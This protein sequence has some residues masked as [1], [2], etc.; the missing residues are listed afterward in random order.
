MGRAALAVFL[1]LAFLGVRPVPAELVDPSAEEQATLTQGM[2]LVAGRHMRDPRFRR[3]VILLVRHDKDGTLGVIVNR[4]TKLPITHALPQI[5]GTEER[6]EMLYFGGPVALQMVSLLV[7]SPQ[8]PA[9]SWH[10]GADVYFTTSERTLVRV[11]AGELPIT[12]LRVLFGHAGWAAGQLEHEL[13]RGDWH[14]TGLDTD[15][16][17]AADPQGVWPRLIERK[18]PRRLLVDN[19][20]RPY[21]RAR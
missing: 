10:V 11:L 12:D 16:V 4:P 5:E 6:P 14:L 9:E 20:Q 15:S 1:V 13:A 7:R 21:T 8:P 17:F 2:L 3:S 19:G 18:A